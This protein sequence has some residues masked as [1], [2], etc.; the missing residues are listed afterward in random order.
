[1]F[2]KMRGVVFDWFVVDRRVPFAV[3]T[4]HFFGRSPV[5]ATVEVDCHKRDPGGNESVV[6]S[7]NGIFGGR[8]VRASRCLCCLQVC[9]HVCSLDGLISPQ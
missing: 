7:E 4:L 5:A 8:L 6:F 2:L 1:M 9:F 3:V